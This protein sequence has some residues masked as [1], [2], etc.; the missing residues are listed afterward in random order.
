VKLTEVEVV[1]LEEVV[2]QKVDT[3]AVMAAAMA[4]QV[5]QT[6]ANAHKHLMMPKPTGRYPTWWN[7]H[8][9]TVWKYASGTDKEVR[10]EMA[11]LWKIREACEL[12]EEKYTHRRKLKFSRLQKPRRL[13]IEPSKKTRPQDRWLPQ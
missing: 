8:I 9:E 5:L 7:K 11:V 4:A 3:A 10:A 1:S 2:E 12:C 13:Q 6:K